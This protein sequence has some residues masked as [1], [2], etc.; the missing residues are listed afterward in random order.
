MI[1][2]RAFFFLLVFS[3]C[4]TGTTPPSERAILVAPD[5]DYEAS[6]PSGGPFVAAR[7]TYTLNTE[8]EKVQWTATSE[9]PWIDLV[10][11][12]GTLVAGTPSL[13]SIAISASANLLAPG[14]YEAVVKLASADASEDPTEISVHLSVSPATGITLTVNPAEPFV[15]TGFLGEAPSP[16]QKSYT[17]RAVGGFLQFS[18]S[19]DVDWLDVVPNSGMLAE[20]AS[21]L[22]T[23]SFND[24]LEDL[25][26][27]AH[28]AVISFVNQRT[29]DGDTTRNV[30]LNLAEGVQIQV[31]PLEDFT[32]AGDVGGPFDPP[33]KTYT[34]TARGAD[35]DY[36]V[37]TSAAWLDLS[38]TGGHLSRDQ[39]TTLSVMVNA[40]S[41][42]FAR[43]LV[44]DVI[45]IE[46]LTSSTTRTLGAVLSVGLEPSAFNLI[47]PANGAQT[48]L[49]PEIRWES[50]IGATSYV[51]EVSTSQNF[52]NIVLRR[53]G[54]TQTRFTPQPFSAS[55]QY[56]W[57]VIARNVV[58]DKTA[59]NAPYTFTTGDLPGDFTLSAPD[60]GA[61][62]LPL[63]PTFSWIAAAGATHYLLTIASDADMTNVVSSHSGIMSTQFV[64]ATPL[65]TDTEYFWTVR[66]RNNIGGTNASNGP[67][68]FTTGTPAAGFELVGPAS[69]S[70]LLPFPVVLSWG[71]SQNETGY[72]IEVSESSSF[73][74]IVYSANENADQ[75]MHA[76]AAGALRAGRT[77]YWRATAQNPSGD[78]IASNAPF[79]FTPNYWAAN[80]GGAMA[81]GGA[82]IDLLPNGDWIVIGTTASSGEPN[83]EQW[84]SRLGADGSIV[85]QRVLGGAGIE[86]GLDVKALSDGGAILV[87]STESFGAGGKDAWV[88]RLDANHDVAWQRVLGGAADD[89]AFS[90]STING[91][92]FILAGTTSSFGASAKDAWVTKLAA[93]GDVLWSKNYGGAGDDSAIGVV[94]TTD[95]GFIV[96]GSS[97]SFGATIDVWVLKL[98]ADGSLVWQYRYGGA[99]SDVA[100]G[101]VR[102]SGG[103]YIGVGRTDSFAAS[104]DDIWAVKFDENG[105]LL[106]QKRIGRT[107]QNE[108]A[109]AISSNGGRAIIGAQS[110]GSAQDVLEI[111]NDGGVVWSRSYALD[112]IRDV[113]LGV[114]Q[115]FAVIGARLG[116]VSAR[117]LHPDGSPLGS[118]TSLAAT[119]TATIAVA[120]VA[121]STSILLNVTT[122]LPNPANASL[123]HVQEAP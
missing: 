102:T 43:G 91:G 98:D 74:P 97:D 122:A 100:A 34:L 58:G 54:L 80:Y 89:E 1:R 81:D 78:E 82:S 109:V 99:G 108:N 113:A 32:S 119:D 16:S 50:S 61:T 118:S 63:L 62:D 115:N 4:G 84:I 19:A 44:Q 94:E 76:I 116:Q 79:T 85:T 60:D 51:L 28:A 3:A 29:H 26:E 111:D 110:P 56:F 39:S 88:V 10:P 12:S 40:Q 120:T 41:S 121:T 77:Y 112:E 101:V 36:R 20:N 6:G 123:N 23:I 64:L 57:R 49:N 47:A 92:G 2:A 73:N 86:I 14:S 107:N 87:G 52:G 7:K 45:Q 25:S 68:S 31:E 11:A 21:Q 27:G 53:T 55:T 96:I 37:S 75:A 18:A 104:S 35:I 106:W 69:G 17:L 95:S 114:D 9:T 70:T 65:M 103:N 66:A 42:T 72:A 30:S 90:V 67:R 46:N 8:R 59:A 5:E 105:A 48:T 93:N 24:K 33:S 13:F 117:K 83:G 15:A 71:D 22:V 38:T